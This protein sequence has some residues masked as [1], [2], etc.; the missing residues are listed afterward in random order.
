MAATIAAGV[1]RINA[2]GQ[3]TMRTATARRTRSAVSALPE[4]KK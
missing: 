1:A 4:E 2:Q 3:P